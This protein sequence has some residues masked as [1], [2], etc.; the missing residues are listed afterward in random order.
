MSIYY[1]D[2]SKFASD[3]QRAAIHGHFIRYSYHNQNLFYQ[4][5][6]LALTQPSCNI[7]HAHF[8]NNKRLNLKWEICNNY[9]F[10]RLKQ[11][12]KKCERDLVLFIVTAT[13]WIC[14]GSNERGGE[15]IA[16]PLL[17][18]EGLNGSVTSNKTYIYNAL[19]NKFN[20]VQET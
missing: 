13:T 18:V 12:Y 9:F 7:K 19:P 11:L 3:I 14:T 4:L 10:T 6:P 16:F 20:T 15:I 2:H 1:N 8:R 5:L 17:P